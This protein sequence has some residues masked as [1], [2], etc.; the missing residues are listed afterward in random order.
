MKGKKD[1]KDISGG[2]PA[3]MV[4][5]GDMMSLLLCFFVLLASMSSIQESKFRQALG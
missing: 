2:A 1:D 4:T 5:Y 3:W